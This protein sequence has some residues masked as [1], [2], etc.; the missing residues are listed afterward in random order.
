[1]N[2]PAR[3]PAS[4]EHPSGESPALRAQRDF[5]HAVEEHHLARL[6]ELVPNDVPVEHYFARG[7]YARTAFLRK[8]SASTGR[9]HKFSQINV[10]LSGD[11]SVL[12]E[13]GEI[14]LRAGAVVVS[15]PGTKRLVFAHEDTVWMTILGTH[16]S[17]VKKIE[18]E[19]LVDTEQEYQRHLEALHGKV[20]ELA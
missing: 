4:S 2:N 7:V 19:F 8:G 13:N 17:D 5:V 16:E 14:R 18:A 15:P 11:I 12:T 1:M 9:I 6:A 3:V 20:L 10:V